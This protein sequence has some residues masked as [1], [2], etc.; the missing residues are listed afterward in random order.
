MMVKKKLVY[1]Q[2]KVIL[3]FNEY[4]LPT[5]QVAGTRQSPME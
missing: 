4:N 3:P 2:F 5:S 1:F